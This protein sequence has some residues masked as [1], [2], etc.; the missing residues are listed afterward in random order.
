MDYL[1]IRELYHHGIKGQKWGIRRYQ[2]P[3]GTLTEAGKKRVD[4]LSKSTSAIDIIDAET[5]R[6][7]PERKLYAKNYTKFEKQAIN[8]L[9][10][11]CEHIIKQLSKEKITVLKGYEVRGKDLY[12]RVS[13]TIG[14]KP[15]YIVYNKIIDNYV[16][17]FLNK[18]AY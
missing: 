7:D 5:M 8:A 14:D 16:E 18:E 13:A 17:D 11:D 1:E 6:R 10:N 12:S 3:D 15:A 2:N 4:E 9:E